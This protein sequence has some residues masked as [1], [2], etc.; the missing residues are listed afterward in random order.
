LA[1]GETP[2]RSSC[3]STLSDENPA[4]LAGVRGLC[5]ASQERSETA[6]AVLDCRADI[7][8]S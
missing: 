5:S 6:A 4:M 2:I 3:P 1:S 8:C 7:H